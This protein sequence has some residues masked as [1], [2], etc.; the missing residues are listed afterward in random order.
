MK[1]KN[2]PDIPGS[3]KIFTAIYLILAFGAYF[4]MFVL[5]RVARI[6]DLLGL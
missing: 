4:I 3:L 5:S 2:N 6:K 1:I